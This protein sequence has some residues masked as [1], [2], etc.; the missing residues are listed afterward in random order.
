MCPLAKFHKLFR[1]IGS[2]FYQYLEIYGVA[3]H[4]PYRTPDFSNWSRY[5]FA[6]QTHNFYVTQILQEIKVWLSGV[7]KAIISH[8]EALWILV[9]FI[10]AHFLK[11]ETQQIDGIHF[12]APNIAKMKF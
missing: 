7:S 4:F 9:L 8:L 2:F 3:V 11:G 6:Q 5:I 10:F 1:E 12:R